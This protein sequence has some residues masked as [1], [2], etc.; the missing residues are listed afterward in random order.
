MNK[1][2]YI[3]QSS[4]I[5]VFLSVLVQNN[6]AAE[7][8]INIEQLFG[9]YANIV[10]KA[11]SGNP[12]LAI[13]ILSNIIKMDPKALKEQGVPT[14]NAEVNKFIALYFRGLV[15][16][17]EQGFYNEA[18]RDLNEAAEMSGINQY[19]NHP[20]LGIIKRFRSDAFYMAGN[21]EKAVNDITESIELFKLSD[22]D[23]AN[24]L[25]LSELYSSRGKYYSAKGKTKS[26]LKDFMKA[27]E[28]G[29][30]SDSTFWGYGYE[31]DRSKNNETANFFFNKVNL[32]A[33]ASD[34]K[35]L[36]KPVSL[37]TKAFISRRI[38]SA[39]KYIAIPE[40]LGATALLYSKAYLPEIGGTELT[41]GIQNLLKILGYDPGH[42]D[43]QIGPKTR[44]AIREFQKD[45]GIPT[46]GE[47]TEELYS[48]LKITIAGIAGPS[49]RRKD[50]VRP[51][52]GDVSIPELVQ[53]VIPAVVTVIGYDSKGSP[54]QMGS[55]FFVQK[56]FVVTNFHVIEG[57]HIIK[58]KTY[59]GAF[60]SARL[61]CEDQSRDLALLTVG[62]Q[63]VSKRKLSVS[64]DLPEIGETI[65]AIGNP[66]GLEQTVS[67][68][69]ISA[70]RKVN[71]E[72]D[73]IQITAPISSGSSGGP[74]LNLRGEVMGVSTLFWAKGQNLNFAVSGKYVDEML[75][76]RK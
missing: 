62:D 69:I 12:D 76:K 72:L 5:L 71:R 18:I 74:V 35:Y 68:G 53:Q 36:E 19:R 17:Y 61:S 59:D 20:I 63:Y 42:I 45:Y 31:L 9:F 3:F 38:Q 40:N 28:L 48:R 32:N 41:S 21:F 14:E 22:D 39:S 8:T 15:R 54:I 29:S 75:L 58:V 49:A 57:T 60:H 65:I 2:K 52:G 73:L 66:M 34:S 6:V 37:K 27:I 1:L 56:S 25:P 7:P 46:D 30:T 11:Q 43:G 26:A 13:S 50:M 67:D 70:I 24:I 55:G 16:L 33:I 44:S 4:L 64:K 47:P 23:I 10:E 51:K